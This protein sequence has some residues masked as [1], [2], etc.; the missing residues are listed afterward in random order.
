MPN[1]DGIRA[2]R[3]STG[4]LYRQQLDPSDEIV[5][6]PTGSDLARYGVTARGRWW[7]REAVTACEAGESP[8]VIPRTI[9][10]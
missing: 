2:R 5:C 4:S 1:P 7:S 8:Y 3:L 10:E 9:E 6:Q